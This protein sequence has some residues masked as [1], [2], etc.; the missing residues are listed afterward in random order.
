[1]SFYAGIGSRKTP[2]S[3][4]QIMT[5]MAKHLSDNNWTLRSGGA[6][7]ADTAFENGANPLRSE[8]YL[9]WNGFNGRTSSYCNPSVN[10]HSMASFFHPAWSKCSQAAKKLHA[11]NCHQILGMDLNTPVDFV[12][13][14]TPNGNRSGGT[15][16][17]LRIAEFKEI[18]IYDL[19]VKENISLLCNWL[20]I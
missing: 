5:L 15:G 1:M 17:A 14:W 16:Q 2:E 18:P 20:N 6:D 13:C 9:P 11:R 19:A 12:I 4:L 7:G 8:I 10:A 3:I